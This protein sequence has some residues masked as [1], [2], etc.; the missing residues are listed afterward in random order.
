MNFATYTRHHVFAQR[1]MLRS[2]GVAA[3]MPSM[4][5]RPTQSFRVAESVESIFGLRAGMWGKTEG[6][7][8]RPGSQVGQMSCQ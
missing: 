1:L 4:Q 7:G 5:V 2:R 6:Q 3:T 8:S